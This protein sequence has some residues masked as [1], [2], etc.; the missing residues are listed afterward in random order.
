MIALT[1]LYSSQS[2]KKIIVSISFLFVFS[3]SCQAGKNQTKTKKL[4]NV[5]RVPKNIELS[6]DQKAAVKLL[7]QKWAPEVVDLRKEASLVMTDEQRKARGPALKAAK[8]NGKKGPGLR[9][10]VQEA[11]GMTPDQIAEQTKINKKMV[12]LNKGIRTE[13]YALLTKEQLASLKKS[14]KK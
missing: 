9:R 5:V 10:A 11:I 8:L 4:P 6:E 13:L 1:E 2:L 14:N 7:N 12:A 3:F